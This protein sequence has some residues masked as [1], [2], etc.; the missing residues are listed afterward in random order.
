MTHHSSLAGGTPSTRTL[1]SLLLGA[2]LFLP[3][4]LAAQQTIVRSDD[5]FVYSAALD[6]GEA[7]C[8]AT[9]IT[10]TDKGSGDV[11]QKIIP[12]ETIIYCDLPPEQIFAV[13]DANFDGHGDI[14]LMQLLPNSPNVPYYFWLFDPATGLFVED[15]ALERITSPEFDPKEKVVTS[16]WRS[17]CCDH[18]LSS[19]RYI[20]GR[21]TLVEEREEAE[22]PAG[23]GYMMTTVR[24]LVKGRMRVVSRKRERM[25]EGE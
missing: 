17:S 19:Y 2:S 20:D 5:R 23:S 22:S 21:L 10:V 18:G 3:S 13:V 8:T 24:K 16:F 15:S 12:G 14:M 4:R 7:F 1:A 9:A 25:K 11:V 6:S